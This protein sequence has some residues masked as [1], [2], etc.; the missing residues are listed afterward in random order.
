M[1]CRG[2]RSI[3]GRRLWSS[4]LRPEFQ[5]FAF[6]SFI[7]LGGSRCAL[8]QFCWRLWLHLGFCRRFCMGW[9]TGGMGLLPGTVQALR[10]LPALRR[11]GLRRLRRKTI[12]RRLTRLCWAILGTL[13]CRRDEAIM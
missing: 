12:H 9:G 6:H 7:L 13:R 5:L 4:L 10:V 2:P 1:F 3:Q 8:G 11:A